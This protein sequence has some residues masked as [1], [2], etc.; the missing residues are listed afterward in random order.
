MHNFTK[1]L[2]NKINLKKINVAVIGI[3]YVGIKLALAFAKKKINVYCYDKDKSKKKILKLKKSPFSYISNLAIKNVYKYLKLK[4]SFNSINECDTII[5]TLP[6]PLKNGKPDLSHIIGAW[7]IIQKFIRPGQLIVLESTTYPGSTEKIF[8]PFLKKNFILDKNIF[9]SFSPE[10]ENPGD[11]KYSFRNTPK[12][13]SGYGL[14][15]KNLCKSLYQIIVNK[16]IAAKNIKIAEMSKLL[17]NIYRSVNIALINELRIATLKMNI[18]IYDVIDVASTKP[19]G[20][21]KFLPGPGTGGHCI[22]IDPVY[23]SWLAKKYKAHSKFIDLS[24]KINLYRTNWIVSQIKKII[25]LQKINKP[26]ILL[27]GLS[28]KKNIEDTRESASIKIFK[29]LKESNFNINFC[30]PYLNKYN[31]EINNK[32]ITIKS[33]KYNL[34][35]IIKYDIIIIST[36]HDKFNYNKIFRSERIIIDLR[37]RAR[38]INKKNIFSL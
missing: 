30:E 35:K 5:F 29:K 31:F 36:D 4:D 27:L 32:I 14:N 23:F 12:V 15:S 33:I 8:L 1:I 3:G 24:T 34:M 28:Y 7:S 26:K 19:F 22:P 9:L 13:I 17:E 21:Q 6:T 25:N 18:D 20:F 38:K 37:G 16:I 10:R 11:E 2:E